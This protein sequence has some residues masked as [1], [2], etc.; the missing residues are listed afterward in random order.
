MG[1]NGSNTKS[2]DEKR[3]SLLPFAWWLESQQSKVTFTV[4]PA[5]GTQQCHDTTVQRAGGLG[6]G[7]AGR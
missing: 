2:N 7:G 1:E 5:A 6:H 3:G 4:S